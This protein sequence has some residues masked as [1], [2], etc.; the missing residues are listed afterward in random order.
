MNKLAIILFSSFLIFATAPAP[1]QSTAPAQDQT[2]K[3]TTHKQTTHPGK[4]TKD[5]IRNAQQALK[6][7]GTYTGPVDGSMNADTQK[8]LRDFQQKNSLSVTGT[9][10]HETMTALGIT[11]KQRLAQALL[12]RSGTKP[13][14]KAAN[15]RRTKVRDTQI[16]LKQAGFNPGPIDGIMGPLTMTSLRDYQSHF[17]LQV[18]GTLTAETRTALMGTGTATMRTDRQSPTTKTYSET[19][20]RVKPTKVDEDISERVY[21]AA[22]ALRELTTVADKRIPNELLERAEAI[23]V[24]PNMIKG[25]FGIGG[26]LWQGTRRPALGQRALEFAGV[27]EVG[28]GSVGAQLGVSSTD[29]VLVFTDRNALHQLEGGKDLKLGVDASAV[30]GP[31]GR[32]AESRRQPEFRIGNLRVFARERVSSRHGAG[33]GRLGIDDG[34]NRKVYGEHRHRTKTFS[35]GKAAMNSTVTPFCRRSGKGR[36]E[37]ATQSE[38]TNTGRSKPPAIPPAQVGEPAAF[39]LMKNLKRKNSIPPTAAR[40]MNAEASAVPARR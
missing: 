1:A 20:V 18:T 33:W 13:G 35:I 39:F 7:K 38:I 5:D 24:V 8:A 19:V 40:L 9:L 3:Q 6:E 4:A 27:L 17:G 15:S 11:I 2:H 10:D 25:A 16:A 28:G 37:K 26:P 34:A 31:I 22:D 29:L 36:S 12:P 21:K 23:A 30:A 32:S 14:S